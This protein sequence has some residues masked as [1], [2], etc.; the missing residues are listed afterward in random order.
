[1]TFASFTDTA[2]V[3]NAITRLAALAPLTEDDRRALGEAA[4][5]AAAFAPQSEIVSEGAPLPDKKILLSGWAYRMRQ[6]IDGRRQILGL[7]MPGDLL[8]NCAHRDP[9][10]ATAII[11][12]TQVRLCTVPSLGSEALR[13]AYAM[14]GALD[15]IAL[16]R[17]IARLGRLSAYERMIDLLLEIRERSALANLL[18]GERFALPLTQEM[19]A[20]LLGLTTVHVNRTIQTLRQNEVLLLRRGYARLSNVEGLMRLVDYR[21]AP[22]EVAPQEEREPRA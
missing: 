18:E 19:L 21:P 11:A 22:L 13:E 5:M 3:A 16:L 10:S 15:E 1:M 2:T 17:Q 7:L 12:V 9:V 20:D 4:N 6:M 14:S 8:G